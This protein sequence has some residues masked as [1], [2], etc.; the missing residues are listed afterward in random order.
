[1]KR[2]LLS[3]ILAIGMTANIWADT[4]IEGIKYALNDDFTATV[5]GLDDPSFTGTIT[6]PETI[7]FYGNTYQITQIGERAFYEYKFKVVNIGNSV[8]SIGTYA[9]YKCTGLTSV[10]IPN[11]VTSIGSG[12]FYS[13]TG[14]TSV[15]IPNSVTSI[16]NSAFSDCSGLTSVIIPTSVTSIGNS[17][18]SPTP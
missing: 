14:L 17:A 9:F 16:G 6:I 2:T 12:A 7:K 5:T 11:S 15:T 13:C 8:T 10:T 1:M 4:V 18:L 3:F